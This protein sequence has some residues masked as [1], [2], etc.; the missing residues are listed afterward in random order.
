[1]TSVALGSKPWQGIKGHGV[2]ICALIYFYVREDS[3][4]ETGPMLSR[5]LTFTT[6]L[7][8]QV[9]APSPDLD[10]FLSL[11]LASL[12]PEG[13]SDNDGVA[14]FWTQRVENLIRESSSFSGLHNFFT[15][16]ERLLM[17]EELYDEINN[18]TIKPAE[19]Q[20][21]EQS[22]FGHYLQRCLDNYLSLEDDEFAKVVGYVQNWVACGEQML[23]RSSSSRN[24]DCRGGSTSSSA[25]RKGDYSLAR[26]ELEG[27]FDRSPLDSTKYSLQET[28]LRNAMFH[29]RTK[30]YESSRASLDEALRL[31]RGVN[32]LLCIS[33]CD[34]LLRRI[35]YEEDTGVRHQHVLGLPRSQPLFSLQDL[36]QVQREVDL[37]NPLLSVL[38]GVG[39]LLYQGKGKSKGV[40]IDVIIS[41]EEFAECCM[42]LAKTW[43]NMGIE[44]NSSTC[45]QVC[46]EEGKL[47]DPTIFERLDLPVAIVQSQ[48]LV[49]KGKF[50]EALSVLFNLP[51]MQIFSMDSFQVWQAE[52]WKLLYRAAL[53]ADSSMTLDAIKA[54]RPEVI[55]EVEG[56]I[57]MVWQ[58]TPTLMEPNEASFDRRDKTTLTQQ[59]L[60]KLKEAQTL[61]QEGREFSVSLTIATQVMR[62]AEDADL[63]ALY[64]QAVLECAESLLALGNATRARQVMEGVMP[65]F[66]VEASAEMRGRAAWMYS[67]VLLTLHK[68]EDATIHVVFPW[69]DRARTAFQ[70]CERVKELS[71]VLYL[72]ARLYDH[73]DMQKERDECSQEFREVVEEWNKNKQTKLKV[74]DSINSIVRLIGA[75]VVA[76]S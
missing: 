20:I 7:I 25:L 71:E 68:Y 73:L 36:W 48:V 11:L 72:Q 24:C 58:D 13:S 60:G 50:D 6:R 45:L 43:A 59:L 62:R 15:K 51:L 39:E 38:L 2:A 22:P 61:R 67:R 21:D 34:N 75:R 19:R 37:G 17:T 29:Y 9:D 44:D 57:E 49:G 56:S 64:R 40:D 74:F 32:D 54:V 14:T 46:I 27:F 42:C 55:K 47:L 30:A 65:Q 12:K 31:S 1:M 53:Q 26:A 70:D 52:V 41:S 23:S 18:I 16:V 66:L 33:L 69:L 63:F 35:N 76:G 3:L 4:N 5:L 28:L 8:F 10:H